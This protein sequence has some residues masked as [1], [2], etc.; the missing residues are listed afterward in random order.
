ML[1]PLYYVTPHP[2][3]WVFWIHFLNKPPT[4][5][6]LSLDLL[7]KMS[8]KNVSTR[9]NALLHSSISYFSNWY[10]FAFHTWVQ[11]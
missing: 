1:S 2:P 9:M 11:V 8:K 7:L 3:T 4:L 6:S 5:E 10:I